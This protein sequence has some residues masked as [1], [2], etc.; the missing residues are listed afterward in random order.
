MRFHLARLSS[1]LICSL[2][3][4]WT[5]IFQTG[6]HLHLVYGVWNLRTFLH[7]VNKIQN[8]IKLLQHYVPRHG[9]AFHSFRTSTAVAESGL[10]AS[11]K[12]AN[13]LLYVNV[14]VPQTGFSPISIHTIRERSFT[15][16]FEKNFSWG[17]SIEPLHY[18]WNNLRSDTI[19][20][21][22]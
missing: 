16:Y 21:A 8:I 2:S 11:P 18:I 19:Q 17:T 13:L 22:V 12:A 14:Y 5:T 6:L 1:F 9:P 4:M 15:S 3:E 20:Y 7:W 10:T